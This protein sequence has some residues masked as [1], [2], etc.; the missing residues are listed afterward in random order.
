MQKY[1]PSDKIRRIIYFFNM[2]ISKDNYHINP[3]IGDIIISL[4][5]YLFGGNFW[6]IDFP[7][8]PQWRTQNKTSINPNNMRHYLDIMRNLLNKIWNQWILEEFW[9][10]IEIPQI[11]IIEN[12]KECGSDLTLVYHRGYN[13]IFVSDKFIERL[14]KLLPV[15]AREICIALAIAHEFWHSIMNQLSKKGIW[16]K[17]EE[18]FCDMI[19]GFTL[20]K[21]EELDLL[22]WEDIESW[23]IFFQNIWIIGNPDTH[24]DS[25]ERKQAFRLW[26]NMK[27]ESMK[28]V[29]TKLAPKKTTHTF[30]MKI[31]SILEHTYYSNILK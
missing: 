23:E 2:N 19:A 6:K 22:D 28:E 9:I 17:Y 31:I 15:I 20:K 12:N 10:D 21:M 16:N 7:I 14:N 3:T 27:D 30:H 26:Y 18:H 1:N 11:E 24:W 13:V 4:D 8:I 5:E 29:L 25:N